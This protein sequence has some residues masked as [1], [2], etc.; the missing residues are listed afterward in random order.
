MNNQTN[1]IASKLSCVLLGG[2]SMLALGLSVPAMAQE[3]TLETVVVTGQRAAI[4][5]AVRIK[6]NADQIVDS[7]VADDAGKLPDRSI[8]EVLQR[9]SGVTI[10][11]FN[12]LGS[13]DKYT[14]EGSG[15][16]VRGMPAGASTINGHDAF[17]ANGGR[18]I[19]WSD[20]PAE[21]M[22]GVDIYKTYT[23]DQIEGGLGGTINLR[24]RLPFDFD[25]TKFGGRV[26]FSYG[27]LIQQGRPVASAMASTRFDT[28]WGEMGLLA[29]VSYD[30]NSYRS[31]SIQTDM[32]VP[33]T[34]VVDNYTLDLSDPQHPNPVR[35][36]NTTYWLPQGFTYHTDYG[37]HT[38]GGA[39]VAFQW[40]PSEQLLIHARA[41]VSVNDTKDRSYGYSASNETEWAN[42]TFVPDPSG[43]VGSAAGKAQLVGVLGSPAPQPGNPLYHTWNSYN[44]LTYSNTLMD[45]QLLNS[46]YQPGNICSGASTN[47]GA[48]RS[49]ARTTDLELGADWQ[50]NERWQVHAAGDF[51]YSKAS[52]KSLSVGGSGVM[53]AYGVDMTGNYPRFLFSDPAALRAGTNYY[54]YY[55]MPNSTKN[56]GQEMQ[57]NLDVV[58][59][60]NR[61]ILKDVKFGWR[62]SVRTE[63]DYDTAF[64]AWDALSADWVRPLYYMTDTKSAE[65]TRLFQFPNFFRGE[66]NLPGPALFVDAGKVAMLD[67]SYFEN[68]YNCHHN[69]DVA[70]CTQTPFTNQTIHSPGVNPSYF[71]T[72]NVA[73]YAM[74]TFA[75][76]NVFG[77]PFTGNAGARLVYVDNQASTNFTASPNASLYHL[78]A[79]GPLWATDLQSARVA[80][81]QVTWNV[82]PA[83][84]LQIMPTDQIHIRLAG[85]VTAQ[86]PGFGNLKE[87]YSV[88]TQDV[89]NPAYDPNW[90]A[91]QHPNQVDRSRLPQTVRLLTGWNMSGDSPRIKPEIGRNLDMSFEWYGDGGAN[92]YVSLFYKSI[93]HKVVDSLQLVNLP[94]NV[95][96]PITPAT[97]DPLSTDTENCVT[98]A[99]GACTFAN[100]AQNSVEPTAV[101]A[102]ANS[103][104]ESVIRGFEVGFNKYFDWSFVPHYLKGFGVSGNYTYIDSRAPGAYSLDMFGNNIA[105]HLPFENLSH[106]AFNA[107]LMY[108]RDPVSFRLAYN[109]RSKYLMQASG[110]NSHGDYAGVNVGVTCHLN[111][112]VAGG[113]GGNVTDGRCYYAEPIW[114][115]SFG[116][117]DAGMNY[118]IDDNWSFS[119]QSQNL[120][121]TK[122]KTTMGI[123]LPAYVDA[124]GVARPAQR[125]MPRN[126]FTADRRVSIDLRFNY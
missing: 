41:F 11:H 104:K 8:T 91:S 17:S 20:V 126:W 54:W 14:V 7:I 48:D 25:G 118:N 45:P 19:L 119:I 98:N 96:M 124:T 23:P 66:A 34:N 85:S 12:N 32:Y 50:P 79:G 37:Y 49:F 69:G 77:M 80:G 84:N 113:L 24:T 57:A 108:D 31:D 28:K 68:R 109:W 15:P 121:N 63:K 56:Y 43:A 115:K 111:N 97:L 70:D 3:Q 29:S 116:S 102:K 82:L 39:N 75:S 101:R 123:N 36:G 58:Y 76:D 21:L 2:V 114:S 107:M 44:Y 53:P 65:D 60:A 61:G 99:A 52:G 62:G 89:P 30:S 81:G 92:A 5:S 110:W 106:H 103:G 9:V 86:Q 90:V 47:T 42:I 74:A 72:V 10:T 26:G 83:F 112:T 94:W 88:S 38:R 73:A 35:T 105:R 59:H 6:E 93:K 27:D 95:G 18:S 71:K 40:R 100:P 55:Q 87:N 1:H 16:S 122:A 22:A 64:T 78:T 51:I 125:E 4:E 120:L 13:P 33:H 46:C 117:L 67:E